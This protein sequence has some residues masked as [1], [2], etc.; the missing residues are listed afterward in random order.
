[1]PD[2]TKHIVPRNAEPLKAGR[3]KRTRSMRSAMMTAPRRRPHKA[4]LGA[5]STF[6]A[7]AVMAT[8]LALLCLSLTHLA[9]GVSI[10]TGSDAWSGWAMAVGVD[11]GFIV[12]EIAMLV[13]SEPVRAEVTRWANPAIIGTLMTSAAMNGFAFGSHSTG[14]MLWPAIGL[15]VAIPLMVLA[16]VKVGSTLFFAKE[17]R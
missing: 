1:M 13:A 11:A 3:Q 16:L 14:W 15:G 17:H 9:S 10:L 7:A 4:G 8:A 6:A 5:W 2:Q 12:L